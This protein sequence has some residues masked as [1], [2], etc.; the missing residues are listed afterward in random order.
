MLCKDNIA[1]IENNAKHIFPS[2]SLF[3]LFFIFIKKNI[4]NNLS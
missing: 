1:N 3:I 2:F 4:K